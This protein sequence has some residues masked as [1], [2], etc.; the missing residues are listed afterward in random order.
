MMTRPEVI[1][2]PQISM[3]TARARVVRE[4]LTLRFAPSKDDELARMVATLSHN[5]AETDS[6]AQIKRERHK[7]GWHNVNSG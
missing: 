2:C 3:G 1:P 6:T 5:C 4:L 7:I